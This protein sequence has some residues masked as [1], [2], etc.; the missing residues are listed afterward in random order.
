[1]D[2]QDNHIFRLHKSH[3]KPAAEVLARAFHNYP[4]MQ[5]YFPDESRRRRINRYATMISL[6]FAVRY[7]EAYATSTAL[8]GIAVWLPFGQ[9]PMH[10]LSVLRTVP[11]NILAAF[12]FTGGYKMRA[13]GDYISSVHKQAC[14]SHHLY[15]SDLGVDPV[16]QGKGFGGKLLRPLLE[17]AEREHLPIYLE[18]HDERD[19]ALYQH[20]GFKILSE[21]LL[22]HT[23]VRHWSMLRE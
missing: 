19:V 10:Y 14:P 15:L 2:S 9:N 16:H 21:G 17:K 7:G 13:A 1:M 4:M 3:I 22:P 5:Y 20:F 18:T 11:L 8:E 12:L 6:Y 23:T